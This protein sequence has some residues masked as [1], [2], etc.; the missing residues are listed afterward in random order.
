MGRDGSKSKE[1]GTYRNQDHRE[2]PSLSL[3]VLNLNCDEM[4]KKKKKFL[5]NRILKNSRIRRSR[6][7]ALEGELVHDGPHN[8]PV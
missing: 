2:V 5:S 1:Y 8:P 7:R 3:Q 6:E 4:E